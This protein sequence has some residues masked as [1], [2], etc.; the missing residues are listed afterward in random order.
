M[1][2]QIAGPVVQ[3]AGHRLGQGE[4]EP[5][6][7]GAVALGQPQRF[8][9][10]VGVGAGEK[11]DQ[12]EPG[13]VVLHRGGGQVSIVPYRPSRAGHPGQGAPGRIAGNTQRGHRTGP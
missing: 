1:A 6:V 4:D 7:V 5:G 3:V 10:V 2:Q 8:W 13:E 12:A 9:Q 11:L